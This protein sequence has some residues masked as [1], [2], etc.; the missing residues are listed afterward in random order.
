MNISRLLSSLPLILA[1]TLTLGCSTNV[2]ATTEEDPEESAPTGVDDAPLSEGATA[3][4]REDP[5]EA[6]GST[7]NSKLSAD[8]NSR[9]SSGCTNYT[10]R[11]A[12]DGCCTKTATRRRQQICIYGTWY[13]TNK[14]E[15]YYPTSYC[16]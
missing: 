10:T 16:L 13:W 14:S 7:A 11:W 2:D 9:L 5:D 4:L 1:W 8:A 3:L 6:G 12:N 15:C